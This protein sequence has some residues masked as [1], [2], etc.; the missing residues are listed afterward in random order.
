MC[1]ARCTIK[2]TL[3]KGFVLLLNHTLLTSSIN[4]HSFIAAAIVIWIGGTRD[5]AAV[6]RAVLAEFADAVALLPVH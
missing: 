3:N 1:R 4:A 2:V 5:S 6:R